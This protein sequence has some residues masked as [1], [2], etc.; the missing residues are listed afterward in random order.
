MR[1]DSRKVL[2][3]RLGGKRKW[4]PL[5]ENGQGYQAASIDCRGGIEKGGGGGWGGGVE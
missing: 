5:R 2:T 1:A 4:I 3:I